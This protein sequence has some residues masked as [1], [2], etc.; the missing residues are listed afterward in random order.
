MDQ[1]R[2]QPLT[3]VLGLVRVLMKGSTASY[4]LSRHVRCSSLAVV[5]GHFIRAEFGLASAEVNKQR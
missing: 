1:Q 2:L 3:R 4:R 5:R